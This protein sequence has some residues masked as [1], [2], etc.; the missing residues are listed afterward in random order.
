MSLI[1]LLVV[2]L[3]VGCIYWLITLLPLPP[4]FKTVALVILILIVIIWLASSLGAF[5]SGP[6]LRLR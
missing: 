4:P 6:V 1:G 2:I 5:G 3:I